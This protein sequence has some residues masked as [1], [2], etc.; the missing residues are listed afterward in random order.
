MQDMFRVIQESLSLN[1]KPVILFS[2]GKDSIVT[3]DI[4][5]QFYKDYKIVHRYFVKG[6]SY[7][8]KV[9]DYYSNR[10]Q[11]EIIQIPDEA[12]LNA[13]A[14]GTFS[15]YKPDPMPPILKMADIEKQI[16]HLTGSEWLFNGEKKADSLTRRIMI[17]HEG[18][19]I[20]TKHHKC[21]VL[22][23]WTE[24]DVM[25]YIQ[26]YKLPLPLEYSFGFRNFDSLDKNALTFMKNNLPDDFEKVKQVFPLIET[27]LYEKEYAA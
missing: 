5:N 18:N 27:I 3:L 4:V 7:R 14:R 16:R 25:K 17:K 13:L 24:K 19:G 23:D 9:L 22:A 20:D 2:S 21:Y 8:Q 15:L 26:Y 1:I 6:L 12:T 11:K 10:Y